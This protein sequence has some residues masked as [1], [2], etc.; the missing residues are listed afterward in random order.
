MRK[1]E[2]Q[3]SQETVQQPTESRRDHFRNG[4]AGRHPDVNMDDEEAYYGALEDE[5][6]NREEELKRHRADNERL[7]NMF[8]ENPEAAY[9]MTDLIDGKTPLGETLIR[10]FGATFKDALD[11]PSEENVKAFAA[12][13]DDHAKRVKESERLQA[14]FEKNIDQSETNIEQWQATHKVSGEQI[15]AMRE[16]LTSQFSNL[17]VGLVTPDMLDFAYKGMNYDTA[18]NAA[19]EQGQ[20]AGRNE[21]IQEKLR[22]GKSD[23]VP[24]IQGGGRA[25]SRGRMGSIFDVARGAR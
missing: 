21:R 2:E 22:K 11:D 13:L 1:E 17:L 24:L 15:D 19:E 5:Y 14:E 25:S 7:N 20:A 16:Y 4:F 10:R 12:A 8:M 3:A 23:G 9:F 6:N 18:V